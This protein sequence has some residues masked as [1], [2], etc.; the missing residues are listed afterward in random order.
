M[1]YLLGT[2]LA[3]LMATLLRGHQCEGGTADR[4]L[5]WSDYWGYS[6]IAVRAQLR[7]GIVFIPQAVTRTVVFSVSRDPHARGETLSASTLMGAILLR[8]KNKPMFVFLVLCLAGCAKHWSSS[9][10]LAGLAAGGSR[11]RVFLP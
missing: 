5:H 6:R 9:I 4:Q 7:A 2:A 11:A 3:G 8:P 10:H 1:R